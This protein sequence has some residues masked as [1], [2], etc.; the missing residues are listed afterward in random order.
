MMGELYLTKFKIPSKA[1]AEFSI[2]TNNKAVKQFNN[3]RFIGSH[4][5]EGIALYM[6]AEKLL[7]SDKKTAAAHYMKS[8]EVFDRVSPF[9]RFVPKKQYVMAVNN[10]GFYKSLDKHRLWKIT[11]EKSFLNEAYKSWVSYLEGSEMS[12]TEKS[13]KP[14]IKNARI[15]LKQAKASLNADI[16]KL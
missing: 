8:I 13:S 4:I 10:V 6:T 5:N 3:K 14:F 1:A 15:Y 16:E 11:K 7:K 9:L 2:V 12:L